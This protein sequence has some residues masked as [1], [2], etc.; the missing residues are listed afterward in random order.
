[1]LPQ[2][3]TSQAII[4]FTSNLDFDKFAVLCGTHWLWIDQAN[5]NLVPLLPGQKG[6][7]MVLGSL[8]HCLVW[9]RT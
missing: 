2:S 5:G 1:M 4:L 3:R 8:G 6:K 7:E 9:T